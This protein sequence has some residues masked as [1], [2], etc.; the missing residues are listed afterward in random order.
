MII[1]EQI[2]SR[3]LAI[4]SV[5]PN[6]T[7]FTSKYKPSI[8]NIPLSAVILK[9]MAIQKIMPISISN[10]PSILQLRSLIFYTE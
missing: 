1:N 9:T 7:P 6:S 3:I 5:N 8:K 2:I 10:K 4:F